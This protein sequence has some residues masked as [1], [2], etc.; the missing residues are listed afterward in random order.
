MRFLHKSKNASFRQMDVEEKEK[1][2]YENNKLLKKIVLQKSRKS[3]K[4]AKS[5]H[6]AMNEKR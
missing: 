6:L 1:I 4:D 2:N 3:E 5:Y